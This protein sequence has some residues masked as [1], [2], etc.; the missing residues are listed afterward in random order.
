M[1][2]H[3]G[4]GV[5]W[6]SGEIREVA[7]GSLW[8]GTEAGLDRFDRATETFVHYRH[9]PELPTSLADDRIR[10]L[11]EATPL[12]RCEFGEVGQRRRGPAVLEVLSLVR[13]AHDPEDVV[14]TA[15]MRAVKEAETFE[16]VLERVYTDIRKERFETRRDARERLLHGEDRVD[17]LHRP[18][19]RMQ[20]AGVDAAARQRDVRRL[21][22][23]VGLESRGFEFGAALVQRRLQRPLG[24]VDG[25]AG[26]RPLF[27]GQ[28]TQ[29]LQSRS[30]LPFLAEVAD[31]Q[32]V[33]L[34][35]RFT[36][37]DLGQGAGL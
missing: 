5:G 18:G 21:G 8:V 36:G 19:D 25:L 23:E 7:D 2:R 22:G 32:F 4:P 17:P 10:A 37:L 34:L 27:S 20:P 16:E 14:A 24:L 30:Q 33:Q 3:P 15:M 28:G 26:R 11:D 13:T 35:E 31:A 9:D 6:S 29:A 12:D 1:A